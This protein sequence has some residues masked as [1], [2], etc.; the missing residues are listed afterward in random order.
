MAS[1]KIATSAMTL[2]MITGIQ[3]NPSIRR[4]GM[5][6]GIVTVAARVPFIATY[7]S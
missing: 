7:L 4:E 2:M 5:R 1:A 6:Q 3:G